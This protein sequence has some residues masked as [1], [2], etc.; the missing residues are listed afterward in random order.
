MAASSEAQLTGIQL[1]DIG[2]VQAI[3]DN[4]DTN[5]TSPNGL[6]ST[7]PLALLMTQVCPN[8]EDS[9]EDTKIK[10]LKKENIK[11]CTKSGISVSY[12]NSLKF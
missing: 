6:R 7:H 5:V 9:Q 10:R 3:A 2:L 11:D 4:F 1:S 12:Q 8:T